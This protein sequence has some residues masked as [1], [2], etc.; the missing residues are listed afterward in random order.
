MVAPRPRERCQPPRHRAAVRRGRVG[1]GAAPGGAPGGDVRRGQDAAGQ[2]RRRDRAVRHHPAPPSR[3]GAGPLPG[4]RRHH[5]RRAGPA[6]PRPRA[7]PQVPRRGPDSF[8]RHHGPRPRGAADPP[9]GAAPF[10]PRHRDVPGLPRAVGP[11]GV[12]RARRG[13]PRHLRRTRRRRHGHQGGGAAPLGRRSPARR[14]GRRR[15]RHRR[16]VGR[17]LVRA[18]GHRRGDRTRGAVRALHTRRP[19]VLHARRHG[20]VAPCAGRRQELRADGRRGARR[21]AVDAMAAEEL[22]F[23]MP[24]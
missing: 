19:R 24:R 14:R 4:A 22:I 15:C 3:R 2:S 18:G 21:A 11:A 9:R 8:R 10:R 17:V 5:A 16:P 13:A 12:P 6:I 7:D 20:V 23:P 1:G